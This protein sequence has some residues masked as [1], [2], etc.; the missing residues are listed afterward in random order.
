MARNA[1]LP[2]APML[3]PMNAP[4]GVLHVLDDDLLEIL[5]LEGNERHVDGVVRGRSGR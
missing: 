2:L 3:D 1:V 5:L 4:Q